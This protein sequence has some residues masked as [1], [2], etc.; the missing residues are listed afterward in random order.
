MLRQALCGASC[1]QFASLFWTAI[2]DV[3][4]LGGYL[5]GDLVRA[6]GKN[7]GEAMQWFSSGVP[8]WTLGTSA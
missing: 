8:Y 4:S 3:L 7:K 2:V 6:L 5:R 1:A